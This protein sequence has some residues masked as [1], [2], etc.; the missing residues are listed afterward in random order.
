LTIPYILRYNRGE[1]AHGDE[2]ARIYDFLLGGFHNFEM[3]RMQK[4]SALTLT[5]SRGYSLAEIEPFFDELELVEPGLVHIP[6]WRPE[7]PDGVLLDQP[8]R[9]LTIAG[10][11]RKPWESEEKQMNSAEQWQLL[12]VLRGR[13]HSIADSWYKAIVQTSGAEIPVDLLM[14]AAE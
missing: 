10:I 6:L 9:A 2:Q 11:G 13:R 3:D 8:E 4:L 14:E 7:G 5:R 12:Q 1:L